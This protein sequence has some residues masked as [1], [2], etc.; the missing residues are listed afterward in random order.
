MRHADT[1]ELV[2]EPIFVVRATD[3]RQYLDFDSEV[4]FIRFS[5]GDACYTLVQPSE[6]LREIENRG[7]AE[8]YS[9]LVEDLRTVQ[10]MG[11]L[12]CFDG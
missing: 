8:Q 2:A 12:I 4:S 9:C 10:A 6:L 7:Y 1:N 5:W 11:H 3:L